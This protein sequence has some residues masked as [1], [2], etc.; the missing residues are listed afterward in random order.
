M[1][2]ACLAVMIAFLAA[3]QP[4]DSTLTTFRNNSFHILSKSSNHQLI[5]FLHGGIHNP[6]FKQAPSQIS[7]PYLVENNSSFL[8]QALENGFDL[9]L[10]ISNDSLNWLEDPEG[11]FT[12]LQALMASRSK[13]YQEIYIGGFSDGGTGS[14]KIFYSHP[15]FFQG[16]VVFNAYPQHAN[17]SAKLDYSSVTDKR[18]LFF[19]TCKDQVIPYEFLL[20]E[21]CQQKETNANTYFYLAHGDHSFANY[22]TKDLNEVFTILTGEAV[23]TQM[24]PIQGY[25]KNDQLIRLYPFRKKIVRKYS[26]GKDIYDANVAQHKTYTKHN[27]VI[28]NSTN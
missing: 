8:E 15:E 5:V 28:S 19:S 17:F 1:I 25:V 21:Y 9:I 12:F 20:T 26:F 22:N 6:Y 2:I 11:T 4:T 13:T 16:L 14:F 3:A 7:L 10:P 23:N 24:E 18:I 27:I